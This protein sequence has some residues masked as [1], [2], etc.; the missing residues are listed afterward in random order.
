MPKIENIETIVEFSQVGFPIS[1]TFV[2]PNG[3]EITFVPARKIIDGI[4]TETVKKINDFFLEDDDLF[5][6]L[7]RKGKN[8]LIFNPPEASWLKC[9]YC[10][11][12]PQELLDIMKAR[13]LKEMIG[14]V[15]QCPYCKRFYKIP[16]PPASFLKYNLI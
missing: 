8:L 15:V 3:K 12:I 14:R 13:K 2:L 11:K 16:T 5:Y 7:K 10:D 6:E 1:V 9:L 4:N